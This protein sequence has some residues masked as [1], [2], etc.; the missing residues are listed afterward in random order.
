LLSPAQPPFDQFGIAL[1]VRDGNDAE[2]LAADAKIDRIGK[3]PNQ[4][5][6]S[7]TLGN[8]E[9]ERAFGNPRQRQRN[10]I[11]E[12]RTQPGLLFLVP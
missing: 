9:P 4:G 12:F 1:L 7:V 5:A 6:P 3:P 11:E 2:V 10:G 8:R